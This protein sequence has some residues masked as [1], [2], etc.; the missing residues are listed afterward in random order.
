MEKWP[1]A[2]LADGLLNHALN[3]SSRSGTRTIHGGLPPELLRQTV[4]AL[5]RGQ[6]L[7]HP[8]EGATTV[9]VLRGRVRMTAGEETTEASAGT[10]ADPL[11]RAARGDGSGGCG[12]AAHCRSASRR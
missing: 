12:P 5:A 6:R 2:A 7:D 3:A 10:A 11:R 8:N 9:L 4:M 1:L